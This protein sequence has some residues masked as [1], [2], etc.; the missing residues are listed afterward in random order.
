MSPYPDLEP[1]IGR[2]LLARAAVFHATRTRLSIM[3]DLVRRAGAVQIA[4]SQLGLH[5][6]KLSVEDIDDETVVRRVVQAWDDELAQTLSRF[7]L[8]DDA[9]ALLADVRELLVLAGPEDPLREIFAGVSRLAG[10]LYGPSWR[11][12]TL[13]VSHVRSHPRGAEAATDPYAVT[14]ATPWPPGEPEAEVELRIFCEEF[15]PAA[16]AAVPMLLTHECVCHVPARQDQAKNDSTFGEGFLDWAA[17]FFFDQWAGKLDTGLAPAARWHANELRT[18]LTGRTHTRAGR[19]RRVGHD[20]AETLRVWFEDTCG[21][22]ADE[23]RTRVARLAVQLNQVERPLRDKDLF[24]SRIGS[25]L[26][27]DLQAAL[28]RWLQPDAD[29]R[30]VLDEIIPCVPSRP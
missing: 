19:A 8:E 3:S 16:Y 12:A 18:L 21:M 13:R 23:S 22:E 4:V 15:G 30:S 17:Y 14:A 7:S 11:P 10:A 26:P 1:D 20:A 29:P 28:R 24:V 5:V 6:L 27:P 25:P 2:A 9:R